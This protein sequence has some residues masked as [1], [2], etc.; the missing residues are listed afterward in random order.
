MIIVPD[1]PGETSPLE[2]FEASVTKV[3]DGD[4]FMADVWNP[5]RSAWVRGIPFRFAFIDAPEMGQ[6]GGEDARDFLAALIVGKTLRLDPIGKESTGYSPVDRYKRV[7]CMGY[8]SEQMEAGPVAYYLNGTCHAGTVRR[9]RPVRRNIELEMLVN[10]WAWKLEQYAFER[11]DE[12]AAAQRD[13]RSNR[14]GIWASDF[15]EPPWRFKRRQKQE[16]LHSRE[17]GRLM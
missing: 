10:G 4:G 3:F 13:A 7:L 9:P 8:I 14:R 11:E 17:Q 5:M 2:Y 6:L 12:Y 15:P 1:D 16:T